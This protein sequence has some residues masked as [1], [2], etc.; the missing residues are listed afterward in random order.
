M[1]GLQQ[2][3]M[4]ILSDIKEVAYS[5]KTVT[6]LGKVDFLAVIAISFSDRI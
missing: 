3:R 5:V 4:R 2:R 6:K 1:D